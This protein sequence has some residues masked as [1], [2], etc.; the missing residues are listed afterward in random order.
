M[1]FG[2]MN[3]CGLRSA[4]VIAVAGCSLLFALSVVVG[5]SSASAQIA[6][7]G[8]GQQG[9]GASR[10]AGASQNAGG[11]PNAGTTRTTSGA[12]TKLA[13]N[14]SSE[15]SAF[16]ALPQ[17]PGAAARAQQPPT[18][19]KKK[20]QKSAA[21]QPSARYYFVEFRARLAESYGHAYL[22]YGRVDGKGTIIQSQV[23]GLH[24]YSESVFPWLIGHI[25]PVPSET[26]ASD[27]DMEEMYI[28]ARYRVLLSEPEY[29]RT[30]A[31]IKQLQAT[32]PLW[33]ASLNNCIGFLK[34]VAHFMGLETPLST[35]VYPE[36]FVNRLR[37]MN[38]SPDH[39]ATTL[40]P[41]VQ[42]GLQ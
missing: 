11:S 32:N 31:Y 3:R 36:V 7:T 18:A 9:Q 23:A 16:D 27:G 42:W 17:K 10:S 5:I 25:I 2:L 12:K 29:V 6:G 24:P 4:T 1:Q 26:G 21:Q 30:V 40:V 8:Q 20:P 19:P 28:S 33:H 38:E 22:T 37:E 13:N 14:A 35:L 41:R 15:Q 34:D 39:M